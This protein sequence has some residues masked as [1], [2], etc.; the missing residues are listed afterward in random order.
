MEQDQAQLQPAAALQGKHKSRERESGSEEREGSER[1]LEHQEE[2]A[3]PHRHCR[4]KYP[5]FPPCQASPEPFPA[6]SG[7]ALHVLVF[8]ASGACRSDVFTAQEA[9]AQKTR[10]MSLWL[11]TRGSSAAPATRGARALGALCHPSPP[12][13]QQI[14][15]EIAP[16]SA[17]APEVTLE[18]SV[19]GSV[20]SQ[21][22]AAHLS[23]PSGLHFAKNPR[24]CLLNHPRL[25]R[26][27]PAD[28]PSSLWWLELGLGSSF[29]TEQLLGTQARSLPVTRVPRHTLRALSILQASHPSPASPRDEEI[30][31]F[32]AP[33]WNSWRPGS[34]GSYSFDQA[35]N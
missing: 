19:R 8:Q 27:L 4:Y 1:A 23:P 5:V 10:H 12:S 24:K 11:S 15:G 33:A 17:V 7:R 28:L 31:A 25:P 9:K 35:F 32:P 26:R 16:E 21:R 6:L 3:P 2:A 22:T 18:A 29:G 14:P 13:A 20:H 30:P 34:F